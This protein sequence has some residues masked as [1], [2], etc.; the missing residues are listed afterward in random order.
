MRLIL[1]FATGNLLITPESQGTLLIC[2]NQLLGNF[3]DF[4][5]DNPKKFDML[6]LDENR[7]MD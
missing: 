5:L 3:L 7:S 2:S 6:V 4:A 1:F